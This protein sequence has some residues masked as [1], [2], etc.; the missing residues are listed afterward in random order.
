MSMNSSGTNDRLASVILDVELL[1]YH[2][3]SKKNTNKYTD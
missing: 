3:E 1:H 2:N